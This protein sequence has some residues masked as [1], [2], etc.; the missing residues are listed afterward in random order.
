M[1]CRV[2][3]LTE[4]DAARM[5]TAELRPRG[6]HALLLTFE[7]DPPPADGGLPPAL[8]AALATGLCARGI[9]AGRW[10]D[11][12]P[13][14][15]TARFLPAPARR[16]LR[17]LRDALP[18]VPKTWPADLALTSDPAC[19][20]AF[21]ETGWSLQYQA[22]LVLPEDA[23][24]HAEAALEALRTCRDWRGFADLPAVLALCAPAV[25]GDAVL[26]ATATEAGLSDL[27]ATLKTA[28]QTAGF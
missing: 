12:A 6:A 14:P 11:T 20:A 18:F 19:A 24:Q 16:P 3:F 8:A 4:W 27:A 28:L 7:A 9:V 22:M 25:D 15:A 23:G 2:A 26:L 5:Q 21:F 17:R 10:F 13:P 1:S